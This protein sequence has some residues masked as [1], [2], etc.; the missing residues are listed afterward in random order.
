METSN[1]MTPINY[2]LPQPPQQ[3][4]CCNDECTHLVIGKWSHRQL[5]NWFYNSIIL[6]F[7]NIVYLEESRCCC[8]S[9]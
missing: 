6:Q 9:A 5:V 7:Y 1:V 2:Q 8:P 4:L 3:C